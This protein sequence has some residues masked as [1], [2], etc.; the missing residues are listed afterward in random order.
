MSKSKFLVVLLVLLLLL[1]GGLAAVYFMSDDESEVRDTIESFAGGKC[2]DG[3]CDRVE[4]T[5]RNCPADCPEEEA[6]PGVVHLSLMVHLEGWDEEVTDQDKFNGH[7][8]AVETL[9]AK[10][11]EYG[12]VATFEA[13]PEFFQAVENWDSDI[14]NDLYA[15]GHGIGLHADVGGNIRTEGLTQEGMVDTLREMR[16]QAEA[17]TGLDIRHV[18][19]ICSEL[20]WVEA[21]IDAGYEFTTG[22]VAYCVMSMPQKARPEEYKMCKNPGMCHGVWP[23]TVA[24]RLNPWRASSA[25]NWLKEDPKGELVLFIPD[26]VFVS[27]YEE[28][29]SLEGTD[30]AGHGDLNSNDVE[31]FVNILDEA[32]V[33]ATNDKLNKLYFGWS[34]GSQVNVSSPVLDEWFEAVEPYLTTGRVDWM[35]IPDMYDAYVT[36]E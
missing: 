25:D 10:F 2:G 14:L 16:E 24:E 6:G 7:V 20:D 34:I 31:A 18:S 23:A 8:K 28:F 35:N 11:E 32:L 19:G 26:G 30:D 33:V 15:R 22:G 21:A 13:S 12:A 9:A 36:N 3:V 1:G 17:V 4:Q 29:E 27:L 5:V